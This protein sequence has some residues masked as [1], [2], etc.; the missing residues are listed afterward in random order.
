[1]AKKIGTRTIL[2]EKKP[3]I[4]SYASVVGKKEHEGPLSEEF[5]YFTTVM[6]I[7]RQKNSQIINEIGLKLS[8]KYQTKYFVSDFKKKKGIDRSWELKKEYELYNQLYCGCKYSY[9]KYLEKVRKEETH[10]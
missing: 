4:I 7:S 5:D 1:M 8:L 9:D 2:L 6:T 3:H 10:D